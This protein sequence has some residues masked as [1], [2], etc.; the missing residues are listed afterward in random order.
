LFYHVYRS[1]ALAH[2]NPPTKIPPITPEGPKRGS[3]KRKL[4]NDADFDETAWH[5]IQAEM[6]RLQGKVRQ[7]F[8]LYRSCEIERVSGVL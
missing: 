7:L 8:A 3:K 1:K 6:W 4:D 5:A 2:I